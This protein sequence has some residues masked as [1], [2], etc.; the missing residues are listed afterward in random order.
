M[1]TKIS[2]A[3][4]VVVAITSGVFAMESRLE[5]AAGGSIPISIDNC[6]RGT[7]GAHGMRCDGAD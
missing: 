7:W 5:G 4:T 2:I 1:F 6:T 3:L